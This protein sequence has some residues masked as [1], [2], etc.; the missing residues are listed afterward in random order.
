MALNDPSNNSPNS[1]YLNGLEEV[2]DLLFLSIS[3]ALSFI[4]FFLTSTCSLPDT[5]YTEHQ[6]VPIAL[7][8]EANINHIAI[9]RT[10]QS[11]IMGNFPKEKHS[12]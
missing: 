7:E 1:R 3:V 9:I 2:H 5:L 12:C 4:H 8:G 11:L 10:R 6:T